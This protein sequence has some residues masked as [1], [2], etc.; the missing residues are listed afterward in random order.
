MPFY[1][2][3]LTWLLWLLPVLAAAAP[4]PPTTPVDR[5]LQ[6]AHAQ[7]GRTFIYDPGYRRMSFPGGDV[8]ML[9][10][11]CADVVVRSLRG[12]GVD[13]QALLNADM[14]AHF[15]AYPHLWGLRHPDPNIDQRRVPNL[16]TYFRRHGMALPAS[17][18][19]RDFLPGDIV[20]WRLERGQPHI[21]VVSE[22]RSRDGQRPLIIHN[23]GW[24]TREEDVLFDWPMAGHFRYFAAR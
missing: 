22:R 8:P 15:D 6:A 14:R 18:N 19:P 4:T 3:W 21:G 23:I 10:G 16:E 12:A 5:V 9:Y 1:A 13:M 24:G 17:K 2:R 11:V 20:S 7:V